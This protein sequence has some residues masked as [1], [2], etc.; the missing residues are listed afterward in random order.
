ML[1]GY[2]RASLVLSLEINLGQNLE[3]QPLSYFVVSLDELNLVWVC[4]LTVFFVVLLLLTPVENYCF[5]LIDYLLKTRVWILLSP[6]LGLLE[7]SRKYLFILSV[8]F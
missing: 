1:D 2:F 6:F 8:Q 5:K 3:I 4:N 7:N